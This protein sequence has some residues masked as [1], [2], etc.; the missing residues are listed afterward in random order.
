MLSEANHA[1]SNPVNY[2]LTGALVPFAF[3]YGKASL[4][5]PPLPLSEL[6]ARGGLLLVAVGLAPGAIGDLIGSE[7]EENRAA[8][9]VVGGLCA[10]I[11]VSA[12]LFYVVVPDAYTKAMARGTPG[13]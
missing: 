7:G 4:V 8:R 2:F 10:I 13:P 6:V 1:P 5:G 9:L 12:S 3:S 11:A